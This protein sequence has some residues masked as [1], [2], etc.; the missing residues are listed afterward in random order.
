MRKLIIILLTAAIAAGCCGAAACSKG[1]TG[2]GNTTLSAYENSYD[3]GCGDDCN[4]KGK[5][6]ENCNCG[7]DCDCRQNGEGGAHDGNEDDGANG[8]E[9]GRFGRR[10]HGHNEPRDEHTDNMDKFEFDGD[11]MGG[12]TG[13]GRRKFGLFSPNGNF[14]P[15][16]P[17]PIPPPPADDDTDEG[18]EN[19]TAAKS[20]Q[21]SGTDNKGNTKPGGRKMRKHAQR[22]NMPAAPKN[23]IG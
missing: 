14:K 1:Q 16:R 6:G 8:E 23:A 4:C 9:R 20:A 3:C 12:K 13:S 5:C 17:M 2:G 21:D 10:R 11:K 18:A 19:G 15:R 7:T 22:K